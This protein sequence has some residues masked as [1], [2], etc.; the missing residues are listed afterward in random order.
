[1]LLLLIIHKPTP[2]PRIQYAYSVRHYFGKEGRRKDY[3]PYNCS[4]VILGPGPGHGYVP[5]FLSIVPLDR[6]FARTYMYISS[7]LDRSSKSFSI[8][9]YLKQTDPHL[10]PRN[11]IN[12]E[13]HG[14][15][16]KH[17]DEGNLN[18]LLERSGVAIGD[19]DEMLRLARGQVRV[20]M[21]VYVLVVDG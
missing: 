21:G 13:F 2:Q 17:F 19:R 4:K 6:T 18:K 20:Y 1:M 14:C 12:S 8:D 11:Q 9:P 10:I 16:Y 7:R 3:T 15:P 5:S